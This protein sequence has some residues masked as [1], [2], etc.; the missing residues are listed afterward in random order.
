[1]TGWVRFNLEEMGDFFPEADSGS[2]KNDE[3]SAFEILEKIHSWSIGNPNNRIFVPLPV[4]QNLAWQSFCAVLKNL[5]RKNEEIFISPAE[6]M[7]LYHLLRREEGYMLR[8]EA[9]AGMAVPEALPKCRTGR[10]KWREGLKIL[11]S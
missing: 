1:M 2:V 11:V 5:S 10:R 3:A 9:L 8:E 7:I 4:D 6:A